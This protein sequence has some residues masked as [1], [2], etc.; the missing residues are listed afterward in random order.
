MTLHN[1]KSFHIAYLQEAPCAD[2]QISLNTV[3]PQE[4][5]CANHQISLDTVSLQEAPSASPPSTN[6]IQMEQSEDISN[7]IRVEQSEDIRS[8]EAPN[9]HA[10][11]FAQVTE[12]PNMQANTSACQAVTHQPPDGSIHS[13]RTEFINPRASNIES[14]SVNQILTRSIFEQRPNEAGFQSDPV[15][16]ELSRLQMLRCLMTKR[17]EEKVPFL[18][19]SFFYSI[20]NSMCTFLASS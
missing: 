13:V 4:A 9:G 6:V 1:L 16:V 5:P 15:A 18:I 3:S 7:V 14:Y 19:P 2:H 11:S 10:S 12:Q 20:A 17:H 8:E